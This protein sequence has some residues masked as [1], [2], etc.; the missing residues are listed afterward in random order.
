MKILFLNSC[1]K[2][3]KTKSGAV[4]KQSEKKNYKSAEKGRLV[5]FFVV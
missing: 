5:V 1:D 2:K 3:P 4:K